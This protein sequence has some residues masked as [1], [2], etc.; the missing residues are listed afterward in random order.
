MKYSITFVLVVASLMFCTSVNA[1]NLTVTDCQG[2]TYPVVKIGEQYWMAENFQCTK[3]DTQSERAGMTLQKSSSSTNAP[4]YTDGRYVSTEYSE[5]LTNEQR[6]H[7]GLRY[8][9]AAA[10]GYAE[11]QAK[12]QTGIYKGRRQGICPNGWHLPS[13]AE[14]NTLASYCGGNNNA[15]GKLKSRNGWYNGGNGTDDY[16]FSGLPAGGAL[17]SSVSI[18]GAWGSFWSSDDKSSNGAY[19]YDLMYKNSNLN[20]YSSYKYT[21][22]SVR[23]LRDC[24]ECESVSSFDLA[25]DFYDN[26]DYEKAVQYATLSLKENPGEIDAYIVRAMANKEMEKYEVVVRDLSAYIGKRKKN[27]ENKTDSFNLATAYRHR[28]TINMDV[29]QKYNGSLGDFKKSYSLDST[30]WQTSLGLG[31]CLYNLKKYEE[32]HYYLYD[33]VCISFQQYEGLYWAAINSYALH[34]YDSAIRTYMACLMYNINEDWQTGIDIFNTDIEKTRECV[35]EVFECSISDYQRGVFHYLWACVLHCNRRYDEALEELNKS[36]VFFKNEEN[37]VQYVHYYKSRCYNAKYEIDNAFNAIDKSVEYAER[38]DSCYSWIYYERAQNYI[39]KGML[40]K[41]LEDMEKA[42]SVAGDD[43]STYIGRIGGLYYLMGDYVSALDNYNKSLQINKTNWEVYVCRAFLYLSMDDKAS[44]VA[45][46]KTVYKHI[47][48]VT[49]NEYCLYATAAFLTGHKAEAE[50]VVN[51][52]KN[53][54]N[55]YNAYIEYAAIADY[56]V[57]TGDAENAVKYLKIAVESGYVLLKAY[58]LMPE[59]ISVMD[60]YPTLRE[61]IN[62]KYI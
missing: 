57:H 59:W 26:K 35:N 42:V 58:L 62:S 23:C 12:S 37:V 44:A 21:A 3:Y 38:Q 5:N 39:S 43:L 15:G 51:Y 55:R 60:K 50:R 31:R 45:D 32:A 4:Y 25:Q 7:L 49:I 40:D 46:L 13:R 54:I 14:W 30:N 16:G 47:K 53:N 61:F 36:L 18:L 34:H 52:A 10:M 22:Q 9:W 48:P 8:N 17:G 33:K 29:F 27:T 6:K 1:Q 24:D 19:I 28:G 56:Y 41:S 20:E 11:S 2:H